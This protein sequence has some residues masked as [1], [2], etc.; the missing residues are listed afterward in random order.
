MLREP[1]GW[2]GIEPSN[3]EAWMELYDHDVSMVTRC[4]L[5]DYRDDPHPRRDLLESLGG[6]RYGHRP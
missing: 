6:A 2:T 1:R 3:E 4:R 5:G